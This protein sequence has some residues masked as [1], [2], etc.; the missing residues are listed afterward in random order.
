[1]PKGNRSWRPIRLALRI[2]PLQIRNAADSGTVSSVGA[3]SRRLRPSAAWR[4]PLREAYTKNPPIQSSPLKV[5]RTLSGLSSQ[6]CSNSRCT[7]RVK[8]R[9]AT[10]RKRNPTM[11]RL[12][13]VPDAGAKMSSTASAPPPVRS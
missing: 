10:N 11:P 13:L 1:M 7:A 2:Q 8:L 5:L 6:V 4:T 12:V 3:S 9:T